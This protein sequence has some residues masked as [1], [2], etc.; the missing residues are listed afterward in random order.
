MSYD[1][2]DYDASDSLYCGHS[3]TFQNTMDMCTPSLGIVVDTAPKSPT[4]E[5]TVKA[6]LWGKEGNYVSCNMYSGGSVLGSGG[7]NTGDWAP[8]QP[9]Q[10]VRISFLDG[11]T[12]QPEASVARGKMFK[13]ETA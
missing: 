8:F 13:T 6:P 4:G 12:N 11:N 9:G 3:P 10:I 5:C 2:F 1:C 7:G